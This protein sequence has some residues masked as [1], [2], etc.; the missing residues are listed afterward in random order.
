MGEVTVSENRIKFSA[1]HIEVPEE[2]RL[3]AN[4]L[5]K[6]EGEIAQIQQ[7]DN[8]DGT[9]LQLHVLR[10]KLVELVASEAI[11][12]SEP[13]IAE[14]TSKSPSQRLRGVLYTYWSQQL[15]HKHP[16][17]KVWYENW[18]EKKIAEIKEYLQ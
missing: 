16:D 18:I 4:I 2:Y 8:A 9:A 14:P 6:G 3:G 12:E 15:S 11:F 10:P 13:T 17:F 1:H 7:K 5:F